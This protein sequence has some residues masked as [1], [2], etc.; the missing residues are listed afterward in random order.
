MSF[1]ILAAVGAAKFLIGFAVIV[2]FVFAETEKLADSLHESAG[3][4]AVA[5]Y[6]RGLL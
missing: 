6:G 3:E 1:L 2:F 4:L 5:I